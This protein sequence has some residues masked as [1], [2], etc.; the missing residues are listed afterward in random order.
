MCAISYDGEEYMF[1]NNYIFL[2]CCLFTQT[3][4]VLV[5]PVQ[6]AIFTMGPNVKESMN[7]FYQITVNMQ[8]CV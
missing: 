8:T 2:L 6:R 4:G 5:L 1:A 7:A 3:V